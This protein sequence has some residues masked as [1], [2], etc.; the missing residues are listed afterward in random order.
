MSC[1]SSERWGWGALAVRGERAKCVRA[2]AAGTTSRNSELCCEFLFCWCTPAVSGGQQLNQLKESSKPSKC[3]PASARSWRRCTQNFS[4]LDDR[5]LGGSEVDLESGWLRLR[6]LCAIHSCR[7]LFQPFAAQQRSGIDGAPGAQGS[8][9]SGPNEHDVCRDR[10]RQ[11]RRHD[12]HEWRHTKTA[13]P[14]PTARPTA[15]TSTGVAPRSKRPWPPAH[16]IRSDASRTLA[17]ARDALSKLFGAQEAHGADRR[18]SK[19][20]FREKLVR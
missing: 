20:A 18:L 3:R 19:T 6:G 15:T 13:P 2:T 9:E 14:P 11:R 4:D 12:T 8:S 10:D 7:V 5:V 17:K 16:D 1:D